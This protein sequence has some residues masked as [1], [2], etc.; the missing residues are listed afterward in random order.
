MTIP[1]CLSFPERVVEDS[2]VVLKV[3]EDLDV[4]LLILSVTY[5]E[6]PRFWAA[7]ELQRA[8]HPLLS[9]PRGFLVK[10]SYLA[11]SRQV[12]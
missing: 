6:G 7:Q 3:M 10:Q 9:R 5:P 11:T 8:S 12:E 4:A 1:R 2:E